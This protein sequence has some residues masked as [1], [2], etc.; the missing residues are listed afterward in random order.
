MLPTIIR[1][2]ELTC[3]L[4]TVSLWRPISGPVLTWPLAVADG[5]T[6]LHSS[7]IETNRIRRQFT[8]CTLFLKHQ[9]GVNWYYMSHQ[10]PEDLLLFKNFDSKD[11]VAKCEYS[12]FTPTH[13]KGAGREG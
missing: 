2:C 11:G 13:T 7:F 12:L 1:R 4:T 8:G 5:S 9:E 6:V 3:E 10:M